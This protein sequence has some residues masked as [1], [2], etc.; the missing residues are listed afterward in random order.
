MRCATG[1]DERADRKIE[2]YDSH[3]QINL[4]VPMF[5]SEP[6]GIAQAPEA[7]GEKQSEQSEE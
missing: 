2:K 6:P 1:P 4:E 3:H 5:W 7:L